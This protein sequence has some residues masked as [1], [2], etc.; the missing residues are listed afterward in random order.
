MTPQ[1]RHQAG[2]ME[3]VQFI[4]L[5]ILIGFIYRHFGPGTHS[6]VTPS[7]IV[8]FA[9]GLFLVGWPMLLKAKQ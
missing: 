8:I 1:R 3:V 5:V 7:V 9:T 2:A 4:G 6:P